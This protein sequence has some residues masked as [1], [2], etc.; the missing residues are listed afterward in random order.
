M[1][2]FQNCKDPGYENIRHSHGNTIIF[3]VDSVPENI[4]VKS[5]GLDLE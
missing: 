2:L 1:I 4:T 5:L 3:T